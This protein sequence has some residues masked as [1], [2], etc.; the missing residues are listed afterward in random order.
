MQPQHWFRDPRISNLFGEEFK[1]GCRRPKH[2]QVCY[3]DP[4]LT[5]WANTQEVRE[6]AGA[7]GWVGLPGEVPTCVIL[8]EWHGRSETKLLPMPAD[9]TL[10][11]RWPGLCPNWMEAGVTEATGGM[12]WNIPGPSAAQQHNSSRLW[13][14]R[15]FQEEVGTRCSSSTTY[16]KK[17][18]AL[19]GMFL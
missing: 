13:A 6:L 15:G 14:I 12:Y 5:F 10:L 18:S 16:S 1:I 17:P 2:R 3:L 4:G 7:A 9:Y 19:K 11:C 8:S